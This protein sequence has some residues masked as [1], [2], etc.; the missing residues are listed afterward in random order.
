MSP[1]THDITCPLCGREYDA[2]EGRSCRVSG[3]PL[4]H[5][6]QLLRCPSCGYEVPAP[7]RLTRAVSRWLHR[8]T[9][10]R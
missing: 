3:C 6:C 10:P 9:H 5:G 1:T 2:D 8:D 7:S 4:S